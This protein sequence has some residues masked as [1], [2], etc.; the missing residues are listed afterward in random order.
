MATARVELRIAADADAVWKV[1]GDFETGP[2]KMAPGHVIECRTDRDIRT[3]VF[4]DGTVARERLVTIEDSQ[5]RIVYAVLGDT[6]K[7]EHDNASMQVLP[8]GYRSCRLIWLH[9]VLPSD[10]AESLAAAMR[11]GGSVIKATLETSE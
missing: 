1:I 5:R 4:A 8:L 7:P 3:V 11:E 2:L 6:V 10:L 9:D